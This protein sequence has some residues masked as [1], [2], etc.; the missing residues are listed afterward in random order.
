MRADKIPNLLP[1]KKEVRC[2]CIHWPCNC[3]A[4]RR[5]SWNACR[6]TIAPKELVLD[7]K[8]IVKELDRVEELKEM[9]P[10]MASIAH[11]HNVRLAQAL[12]QVE[13]IIKVANTKETQIDEETNSRYNH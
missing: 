4:I 7:A 13:G 8:K 11:R 6:D 12:F 5:R 10:G 1:E 2:S 3:N 9:P